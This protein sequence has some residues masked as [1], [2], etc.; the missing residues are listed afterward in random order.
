[1]QFH[2]FRETDDLKKKM[3]RLKT[4]LNR[5]SQKRLS[6]AWRKIGKK[7][8]LEGSRAALTSTVNFPLSSSE[9]RG[10]SCGCSRTIPSFKRVSC[11]RQVEKG[12]VKPACMCDTG[13]RTSFSLSLRINM[14]AFC[15]PPPL[16]SALP[17]DSCS[18]TH[19]TDGGFMEIG[20]F[21]ANEAG[22][23][24]TNTKTDSV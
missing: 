19:D 14:F 7:F 5:A 3:N 4:I 21:S 17:H 13:M 18:T 10:S 8:P 9:R 12:Q 6:A 11:R 16:L 23:F 2:T 1:M 15:T 20:G 22:C 24:S